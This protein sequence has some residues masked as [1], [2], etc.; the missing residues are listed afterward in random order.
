MVIC[1]IMAVMNGINLLSQADALYQRG[2]YS[3]ALRLYE[4]AR[5]QKKTRIYQ[6]F[7][8]KNV[9]QCL[10]R[11]GHVS[12]ALSTAQH[13]IDRLASLT[14]TMTLGHLLITKANCAAD[15]GA[16]EEALE[17]LRRAEIILA[18][19]KDL[20]SLQQIM[21]AVS[22]SLAAMQRTEEAAEILH[23]MR[24]AELGPEIKSQVLNNLAVLEASKNPQMAKALL[25][26]DL[27][28]HTTLNDDYGRC[29]TL[30][31][32]ANIEIELNNRQEGLRLLEKARK[33]A[34]QANAVDL[35]ART[36]RLIDSI[37]ST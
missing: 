19:R 21:I 12:E 5:S 9:A 36:V 18:D 24:Q 3:I 4:E 28:L 8:D 2:E 15:L 37:K 34:S 7:I 1:F 29:V 27:K 13:G 25:F 30:I 22:R 17:S 35:F 14:P 33:A 16:H 26:E 6:A 31:N 10:R 32:I 11:I 23:G 20:K